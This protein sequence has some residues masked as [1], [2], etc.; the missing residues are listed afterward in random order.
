MPSQKNELKISKKSNVLDKMPSTTK[1]RQTNEEE[2][3][4]SQALSTEALAKIETVS[5][6]PDFSFD[7]T[8][9]YL[10]R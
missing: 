10:F 4:K 7:M 1:A 5:N 9:N 2:E 3:K 6:V 8:Q